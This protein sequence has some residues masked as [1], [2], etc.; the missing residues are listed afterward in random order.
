[1][2]FFFSF[3]F[4]TLAPQFFYFYF[5]IQ[6]GH[7]RVKSPVPSL[8]TTINIL[9]KLK[10]IFLNTYKKKKVFHPGT[11]TT[12]AEAHLTSEF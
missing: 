10:K 5:L 12:L 3:F 7:P 2:S 11:Y 4:Y 6:Y 1:M 9:G 8:S